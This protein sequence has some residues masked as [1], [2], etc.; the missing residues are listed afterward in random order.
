VSIGVDIVD[1]SAGSNRGKFRDDRFLRKI[2]SEDERSRIARSSNPD[3]VLWSLWAA[4][5]AVFKARSQSEIAPFHPHR[6]EVA[7]HRARWDGRE[8]PLRFRRTSSWA[9]CVASLTPVDVRLWV[10]PAEAELSGTLTPA[11][12][13]EAFV[14]ES[15]TARILAKEQ[16]ARLCGLSVE[17]RRANYGP[18]RVFVQGRPSDAADI[19][20]SHDGRYLAVALLLRSIAAGMSNSDTNCA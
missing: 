8:Y 19:S 4:K 12:E 10:L 20:F 2:F 7:G 13:A 9:M 1:L 15:R 17:I 5:E 16:I 3:R 14:P 11:E 18:P 6:I